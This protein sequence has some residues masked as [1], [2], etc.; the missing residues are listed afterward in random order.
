M[1]IP[2]IRTIPRL[3]SS[4]SLVA[5]RSFTGP[6]SLPLRAIARL[7]RFAMLAGVAVVPSAAQSAYLTSGS[8]ITLGSGF[9]HPAGVA[10]D[11]NGNIFVADTGNNAIKEILA[12]GGYTTVNNLASGSFNSPQSLAF[13]AYG[14]L[15]VA[16]A[17]SN[18]V[19]VITALSGYSSVSTVASTAFLGTPP[20]GVA[21]DTNG[22][23][24]VST[25]LTSTSVALLEYPGL[26]GFTP[27]GVSG[28]LPGTSLHPGMA[29]D[30]TGH[31][32]MSGGS[33]IL[34]VLPP[35]HDTATSF[36]GNQLVDPSNLAT[37]TYGNVFVADTGNN[38][39]KEILAAGGF[40]TIIPIGS[41]FNQP[42]GVAVDAIGNVFVADTGNNAVKEIPAGSAAGNFGT[43]SV[44]T[45]TPPT[46][47]YEFLFTSGGTIGAPAVLT[48]GA[49]GEDFTDAGTGTCTTNGTSHTYQVYE[50]CTVNVTFTPKHP[51]VRYGAI[52][53]LN[54]SGTAIVTVPVY[55][56]GL[57]PQIAFAPGAQ[58]MVGSGFS[59]PQG[60]AVDGSGN[61]YVGD[62]GNDAVKEISATTVRTLGSGFSAPQGVAVD[63]AANVFVA[64][65]GNDAV[66]EIVAANGVIPASPTINILGSGFS[67][68]TGVAVDQSGNV[69]VNDTGN[70]VEKE[71]L[72]AGGY[73]TVITLGGSFTYPV[74]QATDA[75]GNVFTADTANDRV[76]KLD[77]ADPPQL[78]FAPTVVGSDQR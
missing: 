76:L 61:V 37:D 62:T 55:G 59:V 27:L 42:Q 20:T 77:Y 63:G 58:S 31:V 49:P 60:V 39:V 36:A 65:T 33:S 35:L 32:F 72:A 44:G 73:T 75:S 21:I 23:L 74:L 19:K 64:D 40:V 53:L 38:A 3:F 14:N 17:G 2:V 50:T 34:D 15:F 51:G 56:T 8:Q 22:N 10:V 69:F 25:P 57:G 28:S 54:S 6:R 16:D 43:V 67:A 29:V 1:T 78:I 70:G 66:K 24:W 4:F 13:D 12:A 9:N 5:S 7:A 11:A 48:Q 30:G 71:I 41:G 47:S 46:F 18:S 26:T 52:Q 45:A 68:P